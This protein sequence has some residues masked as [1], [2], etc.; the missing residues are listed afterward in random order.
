MAISPGPA[1]DDTHVPQRA[2]SAAQHV[3]GIIGPFARLITCS[4]AV[5]VAAC[6]RLPLPPRSHRTEMTPAGMA[7]GGPRH[8]TGLS[9]S[10]PVTEA[11]RSP[12]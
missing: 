11:T 1:S 4:S 10:A 7:R 8:A 3:D 2:V 6:N 12:G 9:R 5:D